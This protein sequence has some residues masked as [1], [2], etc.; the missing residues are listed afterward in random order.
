MPSRAVCNAVSMSSDKALNCAG[1]LSVRV[2]T[3]SRSSRRT[4]LLL[5]GACCRLGLIDSLLGASEKSQVLGRIQP[6]I[7]PLNPES[8]LPNVWT[9]KYAI[10]PEEDAW[11]ITA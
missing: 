2:T 3:P 8:P 1:R 4:M 11:D 7:T 6:I 9:R 10:E 5:V